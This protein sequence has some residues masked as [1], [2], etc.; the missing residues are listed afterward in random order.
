MEGMTIPGKQLPQLCRFKSTAELLKNKDELVCC[1]LYHKKIYWLRCLTQ[2]PA[3]IT[4]AV[5]RILVENHNKRFGIS[6]AAMK[7]KIPTSFLCIREN[8]LPLF[9]ANYKPTNNYYKLPSRSLREI[10]ILWA[11]LL[12]AYRN[13]SLKWQGNW[14]TSCPSK[15]RSLH[16]RIQGDNGTASQGFPFSIRSGLSPIPPQIMQHMFYINFSDLW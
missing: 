7:H 12:Y 15:V 3:T 2:K 14:N 4:A 11:R 10:D 1:R 9:S 8:K 16:V 6:N 5:I 13:I